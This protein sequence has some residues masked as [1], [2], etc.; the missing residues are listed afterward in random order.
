MASEPLELWEILVPCNRNDGTP[1]RTRH[2]R[3]WDEQVKKIA[4]G[5]TIM[6]PAIG[7]WE[8]YTDRMIPV[9]IACTSKQMD[10]IIKRTLNH[11][12]DQEAVMAYKIS[13]EVRIVRR[14][15]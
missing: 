2:H 7:K 11:Y 10:E 8:E 4:G 12:N 15:G 5:I 3:G 1:I 13:E 14:D 6:R 9:R